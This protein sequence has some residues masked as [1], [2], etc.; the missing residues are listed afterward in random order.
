M[1]PLLFLTLELPAAGFDPAE[2]LVARGCAIATG[3]L[4][5]GDGQKRGLAVRLVWLG[6]Q[7][8]GQS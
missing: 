8:T 3:S 5:F 6:C 1:P 4:R 2:T 7:L